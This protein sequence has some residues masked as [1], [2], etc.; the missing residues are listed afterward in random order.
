MTARVQL[1]VFL[2]E[3]YC[4]VAGLKKSAGQMPI[5]RIKPM[6]CGQIG[7]ITGIY[8]AKNAR[9]WIAMPVTL[10]VIPSVT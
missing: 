1:M 4:Q 3:K 7:K 2:G 6:T 9:V 8:M 5:K 10:S